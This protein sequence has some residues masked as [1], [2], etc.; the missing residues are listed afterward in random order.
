MQST[1]AK[2][3][4]KVVQPCGHINASNAADLQEQL[5]TIVSS[6]QYA[7]LLVDMTNVESLDSAGLMAL[8]SALTL[9]QQ[10]NQR[11]GLCS[12]SPSIRIIFE[13]TQLDRAF[14]IFEQ[15]STFEA[16]IA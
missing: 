15:R 9:S 2:S 3:Q 5:T 6:R 8:V 4:L 13:L 10:L 7:S 12:V 1:L 14:E 11:F 16:A